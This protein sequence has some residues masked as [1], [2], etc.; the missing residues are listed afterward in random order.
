MQDTSAN[1][2]KSIKKSSP[3]SSVSSKTVTRNYSQQS[4]EAFP[5]MKSYMADKSNRSKP[6][7]LSNKIKHSMMDFTDIKYPKAITS[8][9]LLNNS[10]S[11]ESSDTIHSASVQ[12]DDDG[13]ETSSTTITQGTNENN[14]QSDAQES[15]DFTPIGDFNFEKHPTYSDQRNANESAELF[16]FKRN[17]DVNRNE[18]D[19]IQK[20]IHADLVASESFMDSICESVT[21]E[22][23]VS[24]E[25]ARIPVRSSIKGR[26]VV[27]KKG[28]V[29]SSSIRKKT[30]DPVKKTELLAVLRAEDGTDD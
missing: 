14:N 1:E 16:A 23:K 13:F 22:V 9:P 7:G 15:D 4:S 19:K 6:F 11:M 10:S 27:V 20:E 5:L 3:P 24:T 28:R 30:L 12:Y 26:E 8:K 17:E 29:T 25:K 21:K 18:I 2:I